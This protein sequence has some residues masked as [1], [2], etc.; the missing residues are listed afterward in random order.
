MG[1]VVRSPWAKTSPDESRGLN[2]E[3]WYCDTPDRPLY[4]HQPLGDRERTARGVGHENTCD[5]ISFSPAGVERQWRD[6]PYTDSCVDRN[7]PG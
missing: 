4:S 6:R 2:L 3:V 7:A 1:R 5:S